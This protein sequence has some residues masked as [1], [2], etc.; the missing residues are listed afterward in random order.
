M[1]WPKDTNE[2]KNAFY[3]DFRRGDW[4]GHNLVRMVPPFKMFYDGGEMRRGIL[5]HK[6]IAPALEEIFRE[7]WDKCEHDQAQV[8]ATGASDFGGC[9]NPRRIVGSDR[10]SNH[11]WACAIDLSPS[12]N[13]FTFKEG[14]TTLSHIVLDAFKRQ[15]FRWGGDY[16]G[17][18]DPMHF[19]AVRE[20]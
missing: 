11:S 7:I 12:T 10:W 9:F 15:G 2:E 20:I 14:T 19:E 1:T 16:K 18:K 3:G 17:R 13:G 5:V 4:E 8:N 6:K